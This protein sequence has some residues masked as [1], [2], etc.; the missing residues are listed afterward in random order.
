[1]RMGTEMQCFIQQIWTIKSEYTFDI[2]IFKTFYFSYLF[3]KRENFHIVVK[4][5]FN[6]T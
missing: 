5:N 2:E 3:L 4:F 1:M 6:V